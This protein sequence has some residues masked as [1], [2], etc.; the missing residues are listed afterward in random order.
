MINFDEIASVGK[1]TV[2]VQQSMSRQENFSS[3]LLSKMA[4]EVAIL[5]VALNQDEQTYFVLSEIKKFF[6]FRLKWSI[7]NKLY[8]DWNSNKSFMRNCISD[9]GKRR[10][11]EIH[12]TVPCVERNKMVSPSCS[13]RLDSIAFFVINRFQYQWFFSDALLLYWIGQFFRKK[14]SQTTV[15]V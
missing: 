9:I 11:S 13:S 1:S 12:R 5:M 7:S 6:F 4:F 14:Q 3:Q 8:S 2:L 15:F 10:L